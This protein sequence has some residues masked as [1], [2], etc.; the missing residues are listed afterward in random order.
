MNL[1]DKLSF[2]TA[3]TIYRA[4][5]NSVDPELLVKRKLKLSGQ[6]LVVNGNKYYLDRFRYIYVLGAGK[7]AGRMVRGVESVLGSRLSGGMVIVP[8]GTSV[9][10]EQI[11]IRSGS[12]P[13]PD[14]NGMGATKDIIELARKVGKNDL[15][16]VLLS[17]GGSALLSAP[18]EGI[19]IGDIRILTDLFLKKGIPIEEI[20]TIRKHVSRIKGGGLARLLYPAKVISLIISDVVGDDPAVVA[21][22]P[23]APDPTTFQAC[24]KLLDKYG[25]KNSVPFSIIRRLELGENG[26]IQET[27]KTED[28]IFKKIS[29][30]IIGNN[31]N[32]LEGASEKAREY[33]YI[34]IILSDRI[35][36]DIRRGAELHCALAKAV[37]TSAKRRNKPVCILTGGEMTVDVK[38]NGK[39]GRNTEFILACAREL[40]GTNGITILSGGTDG[41]DGC[42]PAAGAICN[43]NTLLRGK[44]IGLD[45]DDFLERNDSYTYFR[46]VGDLLITGPTGTNV[47]DLRV[48]L[49][50]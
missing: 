1:P 11:E 12:H 2:Q 48:I 6:L 8:T 39:G 26:K 32:A 3:Q 27:P 49:V 38:G 40:L 18:A 41:I 13:H 21:S 22:G 45:A 24:L 15:V 28:P 17:G 4:G 10:Q 9:N 43:G 25:I 20:N 50:D 29:N 33:G 7:A 35:S 44:E 47:M 46:A 19:S 14:Q 23:T 34:T 31:M 5:V 16:I 30:F 42:A 36:G 37:V